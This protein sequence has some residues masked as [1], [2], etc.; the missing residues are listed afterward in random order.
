MVELVSYTVSTTVC[1]TLDVTVERQISSDDTGRLSVVE[2]V[3]KPSELDSAAELIVIPSGVAVYIAELTPLPS[4]GLDDCGDCGTRGA[5]DAL[6][7][8]TPIQ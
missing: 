5:S 1:V 2:L 4:D 8:P 7:V 6:L 3:G